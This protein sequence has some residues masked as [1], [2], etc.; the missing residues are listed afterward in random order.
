MR[1]SE[2]HS[3]D[4][5]ESSPVPNAQARGERGGG[6][7]YYVRPPGL[8]SP[9]VWYRQQTSSKNPT[10]DREGSRRA[11]TGWLCAGNGPLR[12]AAERGP[13]DGAARGTRRACSA[14]RSGLEIAFRDPPMEI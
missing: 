10:L 6:W 8:R 12:P 9:R 1:S 14:R 3:H 5:T 7:G 11:P 2:A 4:T 13:L